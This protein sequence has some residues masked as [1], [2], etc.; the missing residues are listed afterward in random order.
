[1]G[2]RAEEEG[3]ALSRLLS[4]L[5]SLLFCALATREFLARGG[6]SRPKTVMRR[7]DASLLLLRHA[8]KT[9]PPYARV[10]LIK[11]KG[12]WDDAGMLAVAHGQ[13]PHQHA[14]PESASPDFIIALDAPLEDPRYEKTYE[15]PAGSIWKRVR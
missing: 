12:R 15:S 5:F 4:I 10:A 2:E 8:S 6:W 14:V 1:M 7:A 9:L 13:L 11:P 3:G